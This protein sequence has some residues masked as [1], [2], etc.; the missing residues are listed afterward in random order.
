MPS[1]AEQHCCNSK[2]HV[3]ANFAKRT[4]K[5]SRSF[6]VFCTTC[7]PHHSL[8]C[9]I[10]R[11][12][13]PADGNAMSGRSCETYRELEERSL[14]IASLGDMHCLPPELYV[15]VTGQKPS[16]YLTRS[17]RSLCS[18]SEFGM[19]L[20]SLQQSK[21]CEASIWLSFTR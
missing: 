15:L 13:T 18:A 7:S 12:R 2:P 5:F 17:L 9:S 20:D 4:K 10:A 11:F 21:F 14:S 16:S 8:L 6:P 1:I 19:E 3:K